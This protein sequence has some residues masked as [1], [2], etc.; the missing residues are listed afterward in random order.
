[1]A[2]RWF[3]PRPIYQPAATGWPD[4]ISRHGSCGC[5][6]CG[7]FYSTTAVEDFDDLFTRYPAYRTGLRVKVVISGVPDTFAVDAGNVWYTEGSGMSGHNGTWYFDV[8]RSQYGCIFLADDKE[9]FDVTIRAYDASPNTYD[10]TFIQRVRI[11][12][13]A[14]LTAGLPLNYLAAFIDHY[15]PDYDSVFAA[16]GIMNFGPF[17]HPMLGLSFEPSDAQY[18]FTDSLFYDTTLLVSTDR[19]ATA[20]D[21]TRFDDVITGNL[22]YRASQVLALQGPFDFDSVAWTG[23]GTFWDTGTSDFK[24]A[25]TF[26]AEI[27]RL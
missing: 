12:D 20:W 24:I 11:G 22:R 9:T 10:E 7:G 21:A 3:G 14:L 19:S 18:Q 2:N 17:G 13:F 1:V 8:I 26:T 5:C 16:S 25:G 6:K 23:Q 4:L 15:S 27:E